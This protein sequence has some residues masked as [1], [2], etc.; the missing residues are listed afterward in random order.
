M[1]P[2]L[3]SE[4]M[5]DRC[6]EVYTPNDIFHGTYLGNF[7]GKMKKVNDYGDT[8][9]VVTFTNGTIDEM[10]IN[11]SVDWRREKIPTKFIET[12]CRTYYIGGPIAVAKC[13]EGTCYET[14][15]INAAFARLPGGTYLGRYIKREQQYRDI[16]DGSASEAGYGN[17]IFEYGSLSSQQVVIQVPCGE[18]NRGGRRRSTRRT[19]ERTR[20]PKHG[21]KKT[22]HGRKK[23]K[24]GKKK[25]NK[26]I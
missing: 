12:P 8:K 23:T 10:Y 20:K 7:I 19:K 16:N 1:N 18:S 9:D 11:P 3:P 26:R 17:Y 6:Y 4:C 24:Q 13:I 22:K 15:G 5:Q 25:T 14:Y 2:I 21:R